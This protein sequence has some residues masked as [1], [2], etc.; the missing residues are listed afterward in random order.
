MLKILIAIFFLWNIIGFLSL[1]F[2]KKESVVFD[3][4]WD[5]WRDM[6]NPVWLYE[7]Y[8]VNYFGAAMLTIIFNLLC[9]IASIL[10]WLY[11]ILKFVFTAGRK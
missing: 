10:S 3:S 5:K 7:H 2:Y 4:R 6:Y 8:N 9:P 11:I 1:V